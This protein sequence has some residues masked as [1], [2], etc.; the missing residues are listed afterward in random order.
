MP[1]L[2]SRAARLGLSL[3]LTLAQLPLPGAVTHPQLWVGTVPALVYD[4][5][6][7]E[8]LPSAVVGTAMLYNM[9]EFDGQERA[10]ATDIPPAEIMTQGHPLAEAMASLPRVDA[11]RSFSHIELDTLSEAQRRMLEE[12]QRLS[13]SI[14]QLRTQM[15]E[16]SVASEEKLRML[17]EF[18]HRYARLNDIQAQLG[19]QFNDHAA[20]LR[21]VFAEL[22]QQVGKSLDP[23]KNIAGFCS[24]QISKEMTKVIVGPAVTAALANMQALAGLAALVEVA[25]VVGRIRSTCS[26]DSR[27]G[28]CMK[29]AVQHLNRAESDQVSAQSALD[30]IVSDSLADRPLLN[31]DLNL[32]SV[33]QH[34]LA[35]QLANVRSNLDSAHSTVSR[36]VSMLGHR[37]TRWGIVS[38]LLALIGNV[39]STAPGVLAPVQGLSVGAALSASA[40]SLVGK[41]LG[42]RRLDRLSV[43]QERHDAALAEHAALQAQFSQV[44][45]PTAQAVHVK[46]SQP[47]YV[48]AGNV[49]QQLKQ[50][51]ANVY[52]ASASVAAG[53]RE[54]GQTSAAITA[55]RELISGL[56][57]LRAHT[58]GPAGE[59]EEET[60]RALLPLLDKLGAAQQ[61]NATA[62]EAQDAVNEA[63]QLVR[64][65]IQHVDDIHHLDLP[66]AASLRR[67]SDVAPH[68]PGAAAA[69]L[70]S[71]TRR[72]ATPGRSTGQMRRS[73]IR[74]PSVAPRTPAPRS[75]TPPSAADQGAVAQRLGSSSSR[76]GALRQR[77]SGIRPP[78]VAP[79]G[80]PRD[81]SLTPPP[82]FVPSVTPARS[83]TPAVDLGVRHR[84]STAPSM[85]PSAVEGRFSSSSRWQTPSR[86]NSAH[87][88]SSAGT[89]RE[90]SI[91]PGGGRASSLG[92]PRLEDEL[93]KLVIMRMQVTSDVAK[94]GKLQQLAQQ[95]Q[96]VTRAAR[97][98]L[99]ASQRTAHVLK[100]CVDPSLADKILEAQHNVTAKTQS[101]MRVCLMATMEALEDEFDVKQQL[102]MAAG[103]GS[104]RLGNKSTQLTATLAEVRAGVEQALEEMAMRTDAHDT[105]LAARQSSAP[106]LSAHM[107]EH[108]HGQGGSGDRRTSHSLS[109]QSIYL[110]FPPT[111]PS[112]CYTDN[113]PP[114]FVLFCTCICKRD[115]LR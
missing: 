22:L 91:G 59:A 69:P 18:W 95:L 37:S 36:H 6:G 104:L 15:T 39:A 72:A 83:V 62:Q 8:L 97:Q 10:T 54:S 60:V 115:G 21:P 20:S 45:A 101:A 58:P 88:M 107:Q 110:C 44:H 46:S 26:D 29:K 86:Q 102:Q 103:M 32:F 98:Q 12:G 38:I 7:P 84:R 71:T 85:T 80:A 100:D 82:R 28:A 24:H 5:L 16:S 78:S 43:M 99:K 113:I 57:C 106:P 17:Q 75:V 47:V 41:I 65:R 63:L 90:G 79:S 42:G 64:S 51:A 92:P 114:L 52:D 31:K 55:F 66:A 109:P 70:D 108:A 68:A 23:L 19:S 4:G 93:L 81:Y 33:E 111:P 14:D 89:R 76:H 1:T 13:H 77:Q 49:R 50:L 25:D 2:P 96:D 67:T 53:V 74:P 61:G 94:K 9:E 11:S 87:R 27:T 48:H 30:R 56:S 40:L 73:G 105:A 3:L 34:D 112:A 35:V